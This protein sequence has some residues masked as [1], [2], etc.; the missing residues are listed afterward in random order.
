[1]ESVRTKKSR[2]TGDISGQFFQSLKRRCNTSGDHQVK[3][4]GTAINSHAQLHTQF[5]L[6]VSGRSRSSRRCYHTKLRW[7]VNSSQSG[8]RYHVNWLHCWSCSHFASPLCFVKNMLSKP[9][10]LTK[11]GALKG[12]KQAEEPWMGCLV[13]VMILTH[14]PDHRAIQTICRNLKDEQVHR[15]YALAPGAEI[16]IKRY[17]FCSPF[18]PW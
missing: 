11:A 5:P 4:K 8:Y 2:L 14:G 3:A 17:I 10:T 13:T 6:E 9:W 15:R 7:L 16:W 12:G 18:S 1:M